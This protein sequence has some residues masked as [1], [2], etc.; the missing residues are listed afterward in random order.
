MESFPQVK[1]VMA[2][3][4]AARAVRVMTAQRAG[5]AA[6]TTTA[7][8]EPQGGGCVRVTRAP[9][10]CARPSAMARPSPRS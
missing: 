3:I 5:Q 1:A 9:L 10:T 7:A 2:D 6:G 8:A 4:R